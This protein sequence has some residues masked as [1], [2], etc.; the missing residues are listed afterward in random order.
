MLAILGVVLAGCNVNARVDVVLHADGSG[1]LRTTVTLDAD[2]VA[3]LGTAAGGTPPVVLNDLRAAGWKVSP[4]V[5]T[6]HGSQTITLSHTFADQAELTR[7]VGDLAGSNGILRSPTLSHQRGWFSS[8]DALS[9][10]V[11]T[12]AP[13]VGVTDDAALVAKLRAAGVDPAAL[14]SQLDSEVRGALHL[15]VVLHL[16]DGHK[17]TYV[18]QN[19]QVRTVSAVS[20]G[21]DW[22]RVVKFGL[23][24]ALGIVAAMFLIAAGVGAQRNRR[25]VIERFEASPPTDRAPL[26]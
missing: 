24:I 12:R 9:L 5:E 23:G 17:Q 1:V 3:R 15:T 14:E 22:D 13:S 20:G 21:T 8:H 10:V 2:A 6:E 16:P 7:L 26:S 11:D 25:R 19:G 4:W 18:A